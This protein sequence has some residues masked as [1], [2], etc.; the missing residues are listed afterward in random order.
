[1]GIVGRGGDGPRGCFVGA[2]Q[3][4]GRFGIPTVAVDDSEGLSEPDSGLTIFG[5]DPKS[6][7][8][9]PDGPLNIVL[10]RPSIQDGPATH[11]EVHRI[12]VGARRPAAFNIDEFNTEHSCKS[13]RDAEVV[14]EGQCALVDVHLFGPQMRAGARVDELRVDADGASHAA[15]ASL[16]HIPDTQLAANLPDIDGL[17][18]ESERSV[19]GDNKASS[20]SRQIACQ[21]FSYAIGEVVLARIATQVAKGQH[22][23][24]ETRRLCSA[25]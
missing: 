2:R 25:C 8:E 19:P 10:I 7:L 16:E 15:Y 12:W 24:R 13:A 17:A 22:D 11:G 21:I 18:L 1:M 9:Q 4:L 23:D 3:Q 20:N 14:L 5:I 6:I